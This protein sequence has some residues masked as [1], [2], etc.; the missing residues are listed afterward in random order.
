MSLGLILAL[1]AFLSQE[2]A[3]SGE[4]KLL[5]VLAGLSLMAFFGSWVDRGLSSLG[6]VV[7]KMVPRLGLVSMLMCLLALL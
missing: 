4:E 1:T 6:V 5:I 2:S 3:F 7:P